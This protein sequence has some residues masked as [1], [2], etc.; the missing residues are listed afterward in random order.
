VGSYFAWP[1]KRRIILSNA[2]HVLGLPASDKR[3]RHLA[4]QIYA[5]YSK[6][7]IELMRL[8]SLPAD[9]PTRL[10]R[11]RSENGAESFLAIFEKLRADKRGLIAVSGHIGSVEL[12]AG[13][14]ACEAFPRTGWP[15][16]APTPNC[17]P[18]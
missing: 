15:M 5:T 6:Y 3:V 4:R 9:E 11:T 2:S 12:L 17:S 7:V 8:P 1:A 16:T 14:F 18:R 13:S 10:M